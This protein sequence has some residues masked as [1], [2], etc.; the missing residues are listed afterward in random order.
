MCF[1]IQRLKKIVMGEVPILE[2]SIKDTIKD[3]IKD[4]SINQ[5]DRRSF[6]INGKTFG[7]HLSSQFLD[8]SSRTR[9]RKEAGWTK[10]KDATVPVGGKKIDEF[11]YCLGVENKE[12]KKKKNST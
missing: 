5:R 1:R 3:T 4:Y 11:W 8:W 2:N 6:E 12:G 9:E 7:L 10:V